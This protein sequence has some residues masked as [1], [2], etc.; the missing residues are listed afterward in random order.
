VDIQ[1]KGRKV[2]VSEE[3]RERVEKKFAKLARMVGE[4]A[5]LEVELR[6]ETN[7]AIKDSE[8]AEVTLSMKGVTLRAEEASD[9]IFKSINKTADELFRQ[10]KRRREKKLRSRRLA[11]NADPAPGPASP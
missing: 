2:P 11:R 8:V 4:P 5:R 10:V 3:M 1:V 9:N 7:P 6:E